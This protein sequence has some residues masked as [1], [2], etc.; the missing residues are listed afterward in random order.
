[1][2]NVTLIA[3]SLAGFRESLTADGYDL[4]VDQFRDG[5]AHIRIVAG[6]QS[7][8]DC[9]VSKP[10]MASMLR[11]SLRGVPEVDSVKVTYPEDSAS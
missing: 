6:P 11:E 4:V 1:M 3:S 2:D 7:C 9:L 10:M 8:P 5:E